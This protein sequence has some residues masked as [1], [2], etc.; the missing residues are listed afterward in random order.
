MLEI[1]L[2]RRITMEGGGNRESQ[3]R[4]SIK[5]QKKTYGIC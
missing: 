1:V 3:V 5:K 4:R 2:V